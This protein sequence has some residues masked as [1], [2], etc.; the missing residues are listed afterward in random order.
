MTCLEGT[1]EVVEGT[2]ETGMRREDPASDEEDATFIAPVAFLHEI[3][4]GP[5]FLKPP[6]PKLARMR[7][8]G[9]GKEIK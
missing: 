6:L 5:R 7:L 4:S 8:R 3:G 9:C 1:P 2:S